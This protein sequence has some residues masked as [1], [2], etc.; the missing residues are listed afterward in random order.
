VEQLDPRV[1][2]DLLACLET[3]AKLASQVIK[4]LLDSKGNKDK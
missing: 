1:S 4:A 2:Q 3:P